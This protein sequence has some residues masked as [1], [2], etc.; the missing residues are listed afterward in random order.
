MPPAGK[1]LL[2]PSD[3]LCEAAMLAMPNLSLRMSEI[4]AAVLRPLLRTLSERVVEYNR[5]YRMVRAAHRSRSLKQLPPFVPDGY[6]APRP[7]CYRS[8]KIFCRPA[9]LHGPAYQS[10]HSRGMTFCAL[11]KGVET[12][13]PPFFFPESTIKYVWFRGRP[14]ENV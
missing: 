8:R 4:T 1:H 9:T 12:G 2:K 14:V 11:S 7:T 13:L 6:A 5:R 3:D 10:I